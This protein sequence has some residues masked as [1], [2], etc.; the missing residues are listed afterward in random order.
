MKSIHIAVAMLSLTG[1]ANA[2]T[3]SIFGKITTLDGNP[4]ES[5]NLTIKGTNRQTQ[6]DK[7][8]HYKF[9]RLKPGSYQLVTSFTGLNSIEKTVTVEVNK[10]TVLDFVLNENY[11]QLQEVLVSA[12]KSNRTVS[13]V[14]KMPLSNLENPQVYST[15][16]HEIMKQQAITNFDDAL[17]RNVSGISR[18]W[19]STGRGGDGGAYFSLRGFEAQSNLVNGLPGL[20]SGILD[21]AGVEE[22]QV[23]KGPSGTLFGASFYGYGGVI[24]TI[25]KKPYFDFG[26]EV[27]YNYGSNDLHRATLD[28]NSPL[29]KNKTIALRINS[30]FHREH[31]FQDAGFKNS[32]Y[33]APSLTYKVNDRL[34][35]NLM[36]ELLDMKR[37]VAPVFFHS[38]RVAPLTFKNIA[39][40]NL[41]PKL[42]FTSNDLAI[43]NPRSNVQGEVLY[44]INEQWNS[45]TVVSMGNVKSD[46]IYSYIWGNQPGDSY[47]DQYFH[48]ENQK[49]RTFDIQQNFN[50]DFKLAGLRNR[51]LVGVDY[52]ARDVKDHGSGWGLGRRVNPQGLIKGPLDGDGKELTPVPL[53]SQAI[54]Q[55]LANTEAGDPSHIKNSSFSVYASDLL[56]LTDRLSLMASL[57]ADYFDS[58]GE[59]SNADDNYSQWA[60]SPKLGLVYQVVKD[61]VSLF[62]NYM[63]AFYNVAPSIV[64]DANNVKTG[65][66]SFKPERANQWE[67]GTKASLIKDRLWTTLALY[68]IRVANR[69]YSTPT[70]SIQGGK[71]ESKGFDFD[72]EAIPYAGFSV[73]AGFSYNHIA[74]IAGNGNDFYNEKGRAPGGQGPSTLGNLWGSYQIQNGKLKNLGFGLGGNYGGKYKVI[75]NSVTGVFELPSYALLN[76]SVYYS[77]NKFRVNFN[78][79]NINNKQYYIGYW[80]VNPQQRRNFVATVSY[81]L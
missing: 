21:P 65:V 36:A 38:D 66:Q 63:N 24:N 13:S 39:E 37:A 75:D 47:F 73:K 67:L 57:R 5:V 6:T 30:A 26:G 27:A 2:Q 69:V 9:E 58:K 52:F 35:V 41:N 50:G 15:V 53:T 33:F 43:K 81:R 51:L 64:Y 31:S 62:A 11:A 10:P 34:T 74:I 55:L 7:N 71:V 59:V 49:T 29:N 14:A 22:I 1:V 42:S 12:F 56:D 16:S 70:G 8:G 68:D 23:L 79:N 72:V 60:L 44:K 80:S 18:T 17:L 76:G 19:E 32:F 46:G 40:L 4:A 20:S 54:D 28:L 77:F 48:N 3:A 45:Q 78:L 25:T 61:R